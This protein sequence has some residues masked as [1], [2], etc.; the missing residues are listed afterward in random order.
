M[1][2]LWFRDGQ[3]R[4]FSPFRTIPWLVLRRLAS[5][6]WPRPRPSRARRSQSGKSNELQG[7]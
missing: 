3:Y 2:S 1:P 6:R 4:P 5:S 7:Q